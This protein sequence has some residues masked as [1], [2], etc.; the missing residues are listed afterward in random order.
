MDLRVVAQRQVAQ[1]VRDADHGP[2]RPRRA[3]FSPDRDPE[4][5]PD[6][7]ALDITRTDNRHLAFGK[8]I[9]HCLGA[10]LARME[11]QIAINTLLVA[12]TLAAA[13]CHRGHWPGNQ[14]AAPEVKN[15]IAATI[16]PFG[17]RARLPV[18]VERTIFE[19][20]KIYI[21]GGKRGFLVS[22]EPRVLREVLPV[23]E[24]EVAI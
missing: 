22:I 12:L 23:E 1:G 13:A 20:P 19:L 14:E 16:S 17:T 21:N 10:P 24:V 15:R 5:V 6:P 3:L 4:R 8:G 9:H 2:V 11:G 18:Y 7:D